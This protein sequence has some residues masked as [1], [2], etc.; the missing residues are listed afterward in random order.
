MDETTGYKNGCF[1][2][3]STLLCSTTHRETD[4]HTL[5]DLWIAA[6]V[7]VTQRHTET[8]R[9]V[10]R[11]GR[12]GRVPDQLGG[13]EEEDETVVVV[14]APHAVRPCVRVR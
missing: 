11:G 9:P 12:E 10:D 7:R 13:A 8:H 4:I 6:G 5:S 3:T 2:H 1:N 14:Q